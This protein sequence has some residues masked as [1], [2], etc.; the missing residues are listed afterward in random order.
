MRTLARV[1]GW[2]GVVVAALLTVSGIAVW[3]PGGLM[4]ALPSVF[5]MSAAVFCV[6]GLL[7]LWLGRGTRADQEENHR[8]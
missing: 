4:F 6:A 8:G 2:I 7:L 5:L 3:P 1:L